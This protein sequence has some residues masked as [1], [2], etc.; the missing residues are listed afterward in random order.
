MIA[1]NVTPRSLV[2]VAALSSVVVG[3]CG[4]VPGQFEI[5]N[6]QV[7]TDGCVIPTNATVY[8]GQGRLDLSLVN[9]GAE[10][11]YFVF[12]LMRN[13]LEGSDPGVDANKITLKSFAVDISPLGAAPA[14]TQQVFDTLEGDS[15]LRSLLHY[16]TPWSGSLAS[17]GSELS[18]WVPAFPAELAGRILATQEVGRTPSVAVN[19]RIRA[20]GST[21]TKE[22]ESDP[23]DYPVYLCAGCLIANLQPCPFTAP[24]ANKGNDCNIAQ[25]EPVDCCTSGNDLICPAVVV[26]Q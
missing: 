19:L 21:T 11:A 4:R 9:G 18:A 20:F 8:Q 17:G 2:W 12:P 15:S 24:V 7:P 6:N 13:N 16:K 1:N 22:I 3:A 5:I 25:D 10:S 14:Q 26:S 23:F